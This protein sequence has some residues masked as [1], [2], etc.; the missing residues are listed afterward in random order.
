MIPRVGEASQALEG[1]LELEE[2]VLLE[3]RGKLGEP[4]FAGLRLF[5]PQAT[6]VTE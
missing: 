3:L 4:G 5:A 2:Q 6:S 1:D